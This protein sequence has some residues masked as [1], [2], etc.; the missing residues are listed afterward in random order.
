MLTIE[1]GRT[2]V[3]PPVLL[4]ACVVL[5]FMRGVS[6][7]YATFYHKAPEKIVAWQQPKALDKSRRDLL[8]RPS[9]YFFCDNSNQF[10]SIMTQLY[11]NMLFQNREIVSMINE[12]VIP[13]R[14]VLNGE[15][16][17]ALSKSLKNSLRI[18][19]TPSVCLALPNG[20]YVEG[21]AW[22]S[23]R[24]FVAFLHDAM[25][26][27]VR[28]AGF[29]A[30]RNTDWDTACRAFQ[31]DFENKPSDEL[32]DYYGTIYW[33]IALRHNHNDARAREVLQDALKRNKKALYFDKDD[34]WPEPCVHFLLGEINWDELKKRAAEYKN[35]HKYQAETAQYVYAVNLFLE[36]KTEQAKKELRE[37]AENKDTRYYYSGKFAR[38]ELRA[39]GETYPKEEEDNDTESYD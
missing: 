30:M 29:E 2:N 8:S 3:V 37:V 34:R 24:M 14:V 23:D 36:G 1:R 10:N 22:Q 33:S 18:S 25:E 9:L 4:T 17:D 20:A 26:H 6:I 21:T 11:D 35:K 5:L 28:T 13:I 32:V 15:K 31:L 7:F 27:S 19:N 16:S 38:A 39:L 12:S